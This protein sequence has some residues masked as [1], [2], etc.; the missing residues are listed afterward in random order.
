MATLVEYTPKLQQAVDAVMSSL[1]YK[2]NTPQYRKG[3]SS[4][5]EPMSEGDSPQPHIYNCHVVCENVNGDEESGRTAN[6]KIADNAICLVKF[7]YSS[8]QEVKIENKYYY[9]LMPYGKNRTLQQAGYINDIIYSVK[10]PCVVF[11]RSRRDVSTKETNKCLL[12]CEPC[13]DG[14][15]RFSKDSE[16]DERNYDSTARGDIAVLAYIDKAGVVTQLEKGIPSL[17]L[18]KD[19]PDDLDDMIGNLMPER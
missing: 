1:G 9:F 5:D 8:W 3:R 2:V 13:Q 18:L 15:Y 19:R 4:L 7:I 17:M 11:L 10:L 14:A 6:V 16:Y 12:V